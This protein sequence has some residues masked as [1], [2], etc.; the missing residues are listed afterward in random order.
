MFLLKH[1]L[2]PTA[3]RD[4]GSPALAYRLP[5]LSRMV[6]KS[7]T[8]G[9]SFSQELTDTWSDLIACDEKFDTGRESLA[10]LCRRSSVAVS[11]HCRFACLRSCGDACTGESVV[12]TPGGP[13]T[14]SPSMSVSP[15]ILFP[16]FMSWSAS[17]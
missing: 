7:S 10:A 16:C 3:S 12:G 8:P 2:G 14:S 11:T 5:V 4:R 1:L 17:W 6:D 15:F 9:T 13:E